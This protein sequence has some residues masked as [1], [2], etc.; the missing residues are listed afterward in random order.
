MR[1]YCKAFDE[2]NG[3]DKYAMASGSLPHDLHIYG[4]TARDCGQA[5]AGINLGTINYAAS[6]DK[7]CRC[8]ICETS[9]MTSN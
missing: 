1:V 4:T 9:V 2:R 6:D 7:L 5:F 3:S 8:L